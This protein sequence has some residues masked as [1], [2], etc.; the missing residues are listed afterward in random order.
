MS[1]SFENCEV[2]HCTDKALKVHIPE[3]DTEPLWVPR[4]AVH[5]D[6]EIYE[7]GSVGSPGTE[8]TLVVADRFAEDEGWV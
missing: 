6:S 1:V 4:W 5:D 7:G 2:V 3:L 8:G